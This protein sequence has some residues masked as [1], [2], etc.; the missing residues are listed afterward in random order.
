MKKL[1]VLFITLITFTN[2]GYASFPV[3]RE[4]IIS[5]DTIIPDTNKIVKKETK[6]EYHKR[7]EKEGFDIENC[8][9]DDCRKFKNVTL[10]LIPDTIKRYYQQGFIVEA[11]LGTVYAPNL[12]NLT[13]VFHFKNRFSWHISAGIPSFTSGFSFSN[14]RNSQYSLVL[15]KVIGDAFCLRFAWEKENQISEKLFW[16][17]GV[18]VPIIMFDY[19]TRMDD[20]D[21]EYTGWEVSSLISTAGSLD[22][23]DFY[24]LPLINIRYKL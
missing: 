19:G 4:T 8:M 11:G 2:V 5:I 10:N 1:L 24:P 14:E 22:A 21:N 23:F 3:L 12:L 7:M 9:C 18:Q 13:Y 17:Y 6:E 15:G 20:Y 16:C